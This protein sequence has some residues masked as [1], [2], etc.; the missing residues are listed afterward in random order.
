MLAL[1]NGF[2]NIKRLLAG[3]CELSCVFWLFNGREIVSP[4]MG[5]RSFAVIAEFKRDNPKAADWL[6]S[7]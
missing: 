6:A 2:W 7:S 5:Q 3:F 1:L 4:H